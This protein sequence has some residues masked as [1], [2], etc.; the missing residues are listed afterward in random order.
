MVYTHCLGWD[1]RSHLNSPVADG[2]SC[3]MGPAFIFLIKMQ[4]NV[5]LGIIMDQMGKLWGKNFFK[6]TNP[7]VSVLPDFTFLILDLFFCLF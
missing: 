7:Q 5:I 4:P 3:R 6:K 2:G 1:M